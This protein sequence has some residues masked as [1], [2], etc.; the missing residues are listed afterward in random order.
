MKTMVEIPE[1][2]VQQA[3]SITRIA[4]DNELVVY[5]LERLVNSNPLAAIKQYKGQ[6]DLD[7]NVDV[8]RGRS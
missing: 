7:I 3:R 4:S 6:L 5:A 2:L 1:S 8:L